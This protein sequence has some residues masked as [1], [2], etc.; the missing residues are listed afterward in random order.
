MTD[1]QYLSLCE[2]YL[3]GTCSLQEE[4]LLKQ[5]QEKLGIGDDVW[6]TE[7]LG[8]QD[9]I[10]KLVQQKLQQSLPQQQTNVVRI[11]RWWYA[12]AAIL[13]FAIAGV[14]FIK[15]DK[16][17]QTY[18]AANNIKKAPADIQPGSSKAVLTLSTGKSIVLDG[19]GNGLISQQGG[20]AISKTGNG[21]IVK[22][23]DGTTAADATALNT[24][25]IPRGGKYDIT[26][27][28]GTRVWLNSSSSLTF[29][30]AF[31]GSERKISLVGE[32]YFEVAKN[33]NMPFKINVN[34]KQVVEVL[35]THF[36]VTA[37]ADERDITTTLLEGSVKINYQNKSTL[38]K[39]GEMAVNN[40]GAGVTVLPA[41]IDEVMAW[42]NGMFMF[43]N[44][45]IISTMKKISRWYDVDVVFKGN[46]D[47]V[48]LIGNYSRNKSLTNLLKNIELMDKVHFVIEGRRITVISK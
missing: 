22:N 47:H 44:E 18:T 48:N 3:N 45:N 24:I 11:N 32:A 16:S 36:N 27:P 5:H 35:G 9:R 43:N 6:D 15:A 33:K 23:A 28:D 46:M 14:Y 13:I 10:K 20:T 7:L 29:P 39:P 25:T 1:K 21:L 19:A 42:K 41:D 12:A 37:Y 4:S 34:G 31:K 8:Q 40:L 17:N 30:T 26:L 2:K 38:I